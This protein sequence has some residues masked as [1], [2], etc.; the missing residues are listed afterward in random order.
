MA[1]FTTNNAYKGTATFRLFMA[2]LL[3][4][5]AYLNGTLSYFMFL[6]VAPVASFLLIF[7]TDPKASLAKI[8][9]T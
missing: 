9:H 5:I 3:T 1:F 7:I 8:Y 4:P 2:N 6:T